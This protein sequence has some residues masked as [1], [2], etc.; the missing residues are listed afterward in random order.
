M[1]LRAALADGV[2]RSTGRERASVGTSIHSAPPAPVKTERVSA[3][4]GAA[5][6]LRRQIFRTASD[7][8]SE[9]SKGRLDGFRDAGVA[10]PALIL[11]L[12]ALDGDGIAG[13]VKIRQR[14]IL[15]DPAAVDLVGEHEL[16]RFIVDFKDEV[17]AE[18]AQGDFGAGPSP[19][20]PHLE[21][22]GLELLIMSDGP[23]QGDRL[24]ARAARGLPAG[25]EI[26]ARAML[27]DFGRT[28]ERTHLA[29]AG[30]V[31]TVP[32]HSEFEV[33]VGIKAVR[34]HSKLRHLR[35]PRRRRRSARSLRARLRQSGAPAST[36]TAGAKLL[37]SRLERPD[38]P[39]DLV[40]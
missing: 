29:H 30:N 12:D 16:A 7:R 18:I 26:P 4:R 8:G 9:R 21:G 27:D 1:A 39:G 32:L 6:H 28:L 19:E 40:V 2:P 38:R 31:P 15:R 13:G 10:F 11:Q 33:L 20:I 34:V 37:R 23:F 35:P 36:K 14:L 5:R 24:I 25:A 17:L 3:L 22:P